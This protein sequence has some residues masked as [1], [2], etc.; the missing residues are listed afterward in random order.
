MLDCLDEAGLAEARGEDAVEGGGEDWP[1]AYRYCPMDRAASLCCVV[2]W[3]HATWGEPAFTG[4]SS[5]HNFNRLVLDNG[6][7]AQHETLAR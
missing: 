3:W 2:A 4:V 1:D 7:A 5:T 6:G